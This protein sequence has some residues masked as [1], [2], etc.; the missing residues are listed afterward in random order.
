MACCRAA[1]LLGRKCEGVSSRAAEG[2]R[3]DHSEV[4]GSLLASFAATSLQLDEGSVYVGMF[5]LPLA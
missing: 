5:S 2:H 4:M 1:G 3:T